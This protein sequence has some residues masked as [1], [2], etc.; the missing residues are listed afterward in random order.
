MSRSLSDRLSSTLAH[1]TGLG[2]IT[3][4]NIR[5]TVRQIRMAL[6]EADVALPVTKTF[7]ERVRVRAFGEEVAKSLNPG[8]AFVKIVHDE[9]VLVLGGDTVEI[10]RQDNP[11][12][13]ML[14]GLQG[15]GKTTTA[16]KLAKYLAGARGDDVLLV[17]TDL[18]RPAAR[19]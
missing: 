3:E 11:T 13:I 9:L 8:Q 19:Q 16:G 15:A 10:T 18:H 14:V 2:R 5:D 17:S 12:V 1:V 6:L 7:I 4:D